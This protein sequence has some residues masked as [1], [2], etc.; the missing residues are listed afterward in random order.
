M[1]YV[2]SIFVQTV[3]TEI[4]SV[5]VTCTDDEKESLKA[6]EKALDSA[7][8]ELNAA[9]EATMADLAGKRFFQQ[10]VVINKRMEVINIDIYLI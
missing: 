3:A 6:Q 4:A 2:F 10:A 9:L 5:T 7:A 8:E 1:I